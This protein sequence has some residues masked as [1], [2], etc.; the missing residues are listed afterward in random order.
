HSR[1]GPKPSLEAYCSASRGAC[2]STVSQAALIASTGKVSALGRPPAIDRMPG[3][4]VTL[5][6]SRMMEGFMRAARRACCQAAVF[7]VFRLTPGI[8]DC[9]SCSLGRGSR[10]A[11]WGPGQADADGPAVAA[12]D[13]RAG[14]VGRA[15][16]V[17]EPGEAVQAQARRKLAADGG[18]EAPGM[19]AGA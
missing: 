12:R 4:S 15:A 18:V 19:Q 10:R 9:L 7:M 14:A 6:I 17:V 11:P 5:R 2:V 8:A 13:E 16:H 1:S 3:F